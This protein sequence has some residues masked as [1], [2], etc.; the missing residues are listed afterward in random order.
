MVWCV[1]PSNILNCCS[2]EFGYLCDAP[3]ISTYL[4]FMAP[5][6]SLALDPP[7]VMPIKWRIAT[8]RVSETHG[9]FALLQQLFFLHLLSTFLSKKSSLTSCLTEIYFNTI[10]SS[11]FMSSEVFFF[12]VGPPSWFFHLLLHATCFAYL[13][14][15]CYHVRSRICGEECKL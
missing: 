6:A 10:L 7:K 11:T 2:D 12:A 14:V 9:R 3:F 8:C 13:I 1:L 15:Y 4:N 5:L